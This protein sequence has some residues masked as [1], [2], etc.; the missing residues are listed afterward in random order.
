MPDRVQRVVGLLGS[1]MLLPL[2]AVLALLVRATSP[3]PA[4][5]RATRVGAGGK[6]FICYKLRTMRRDAAS[7]GPAISTSEDSRITPFGSLLRRTHLDELP[8]LWNVAR[9]EMRLVGPRPE[10][11]EF[12]DLDDPIGRLVFTQKPGITG[13]AQLLYADEAVLLSGDA[14]LSTYREVIQPG[15]LRVDAA[16]LA[17]RSMSLD[18]WL[19]GQTLLLAL[20]RGPSAETVHARLGLTGTP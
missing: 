20:G 15:K 3:G 1:L 6:P 10:A 11:P 9:G 8:Q 5:Y 19:L 14:P 13:A 12:A 4:L 7:T 17:R 16:Y 18:A 2:T